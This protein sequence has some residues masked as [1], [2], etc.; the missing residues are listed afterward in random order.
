MNFNFLAKVDRYYAFCV[1]N[2]SYSFTPIPS[3]LYRCLGYGLTMCIIFRYNPQMM[4]CYL[5]IDTRYIVCATPPI[6]LILNM[7]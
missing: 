1:Y 7:V 3:K 2:F 6:V 5:F 4:F